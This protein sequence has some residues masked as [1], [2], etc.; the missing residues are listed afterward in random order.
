MAVGEKKNGKSWMKISRDFVSFVCTAKWILQVLG[1]ENEIYLFF[2]KN[3]FVF[4]LVCQKAS[5]SKEVNSRR[6]V[7]IAFSEVIKLEIA[8]LVENISVKNVNS[9]RGK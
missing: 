3:V 8:M 1:T 7:L 4:N 6:P 9:W 5:V 2:S